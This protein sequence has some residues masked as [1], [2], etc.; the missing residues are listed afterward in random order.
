[1]PPVTPEF[2]RQGAKDAKR[3]SGFLRA[4]AVKLFRGWKREWALPLALFLVLRLVASSLGWVTASGPDPERLSADPVY[5]AADSLLKPGRLSHLLVNVWERWD[6]GWYL[7]IAAFGYDPADGTA[8]FSP[9]YPWLT[10]GLTALSGDFL[11]SGLLLSNLAALAAFILFYEVAR[12]EGLDPGRAQGAVIFLAFFPSAFFFLAAY[13]DSLFL[14]FVLGAWLAARRRKWLPAGL[15]GGLAALTRLQGALLTPVLAWAW[16]AWVAEPPGTARQVFAL[17]AGRAGWRRALAALRNPSWMA[18]LLPAL[19]FAWH[20]FWLRLAGL[21]SVPGTLEAHWGI[22]TVA[23]WTGVWLFL[24]RLFTTPRVF[25]D[26]VDLSALLVVLVLLALGWRRLHPAL[27]LYGWLSVGLF[28]MRGTPPHLLD[29]FSRY[30]LAVFPAFLVLG[31]VRSRGL[32]IGLWAVSFV[33]QVFL[34]MGF[35]DW[36]WVA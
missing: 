32:R 31:R 10:R 1:M 25:V 34:L 20:S 29:S 36:R 21:G 11:L 14:A 8:S 22:R 17:A 27:S 30:M 5:A 23:P 24:Q 28:F 18:T 3:D 33:V 7:K 2:H 15:L 6:T 13:T 9:L 12:A 16:L 4:L 19:A 26:Y 35:L